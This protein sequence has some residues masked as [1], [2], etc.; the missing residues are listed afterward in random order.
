MNSI[1]KPKITT[2][3]R[4]METALALMLQEGYHGVSVDRIIEESGVSKGTFFYHFKSKEA[5]AERLLSR[6]INRMGTAL[7]E[8]VTSI[9]SEDLSPFEQLMQIFE[10]FPHQVAHSK[11]CLMAAFSYQLVSENALLREIS[12]E[13]LQGWRDYLSPRFQRALPQ[14]DTEQSEQLAQMMFCLMEGAFV[15]DRIQQNDEI[16]IQFAHF[17][18]YLQLLKR[19]LEGQQR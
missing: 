3:D 9:E 18:R 1:P 17:R 10:R 12:Q 7:Q 13:A 11:G 6:F 19:D 4:I 8:L 5:L 15:A 2:P 16:D 14:L